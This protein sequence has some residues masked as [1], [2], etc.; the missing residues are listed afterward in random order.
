MR[1]LIGVLLVISLIVWLYPGRAAAEE[2]SFETVFKDGFYGGLAGALVGG[3]ILVFRD[4]P[5]DHLNYLSY[6]AA[7]GVI[8][9]TTFGIVSASRS[10]AEIDDHKVVFHLPIPNVSSVPVERVHREVITTI[11]LVTVRF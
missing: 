8:V 9:G 11:G 7:I 4:H 3:A 10:M 5:G 6:G 2:N 1:K